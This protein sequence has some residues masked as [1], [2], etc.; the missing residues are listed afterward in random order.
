[1]TIRYEWKIEEMDSYPSHNGKNN[2]VYN[3]KWR[4]D[5]IEDDYC[6]KLYGITSVTF[7]DSSPFT[8]YDNLTNDQVVEWV[9]SSM[10]D[11]EIFKIESDLLEEINDKK[12][13]KSVINSLPWNVR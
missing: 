9:K 10:K 4:C 2:V 8:E 5:A 7:D 3:I 1:M 13:P 6:A 11:E 12:N